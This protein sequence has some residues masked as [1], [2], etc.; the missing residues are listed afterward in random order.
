MADLL[1]CDNVQILNNGNIRCNGNFTIVDSE[2]LTNESALNALTDLAEILNSIF[3]QPDTDAMITAFMAGITLPF[4]TYLTAWG[5]GL[6]I[7]FAGK[8][9]DPVELD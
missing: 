4:V 1:A 8:S 6:V 2:S 7:K 5:Y 9:H 3:A